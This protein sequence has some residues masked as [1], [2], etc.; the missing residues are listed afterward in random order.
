MFDNNMLRDIRN[1]IN[2]R[3]LAHAM[4]VEMYSKYRQEMFVCP[5]CGFRKATFHPRAN[6]GRCWK[7]K[8]RFNPIEITMAVMRCSFVR[9]VRYLLQ[10]W[11]EFEN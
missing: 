7:C 10:N 2:V 9:A 11:G 1:R 6:I 5:S 4:G 8:Q 3:T